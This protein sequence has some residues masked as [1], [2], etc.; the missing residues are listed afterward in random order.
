MLGDPLTDLSLALETDYFRQASDRY[1][2]PVSV[3]MPGSDLE[4]AK[5]GSAESTRLDFIGE[6]RDA[7]NVIQGSVRDFITVKLSGETAKQLAKKT[8]AYD[9]GFVLPPGSYSV[10]FLAR[11]N[12]T[13][14]M[15]TFQAKFVVPDL[16]VDKQYLPISSVI[17]SNQREQTAAVGGVR[18]NGRLFGRNPL[19]ENGQKLIPSVTRVFRKD[20]D[21]YVFLQ[22]YEPAATT[23]QPLVASL[24]FYRGNERMVKAFEAEP[25]QITDGLNPNTKAV[26]IRFVIPLSKLEPGR[27]TCQVSVLEP[28]VQRFAFWRAPVTLLP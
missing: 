15:G 8:V 16:S 11:E 25:L 14:K 6:V 5:H 4:L 27:Y 3:K 12:E 20:Q 21:M 22:A 13:G 7:K 1:Y 2:V 23:T 19:V 24:A 10:K 28:D 9:T 18:M 17:L 26:P